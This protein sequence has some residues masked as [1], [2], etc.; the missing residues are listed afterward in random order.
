[1][2]PVLPGGVCVCFVMF[3]AST[4]FLSHTTNSNPINPLLRRPRSSESLQCQ[5]HDVSDMTGYK[6]EC[7]TT[8][9]KIEIDGVVIYSAICDDATVVTSNK[10]PC[11]AFVQ[12]LGNVNIN[13]FCYPQGRE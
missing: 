5:A 2:G 12:K 10:T 9:K 8:Y 7:N 6:D 11:T 1:M 3:V 4:I 13:V